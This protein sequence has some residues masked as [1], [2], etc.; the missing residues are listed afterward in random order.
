MFERITVVPIGGT[1]SKFTQAGKNRTGNFHVTVSSSTTGLKVTGEPCPPYFQAWVTKRSAKKG[2]LL[3]HTIS[4]DSSSRRTKRL[5]IRVGLNL[6]ID[7]DGNP[8]N[9]DYNYV[10]SKEW[11]L[12]IINH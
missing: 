12:F 10:D 8:N 4:L 11:R 5:K 1:V 6:M 2:D 3:P 9:A 7:H